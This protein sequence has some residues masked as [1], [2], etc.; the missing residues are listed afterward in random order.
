[1]KRYILIIFL[2]FTGCRKVDCN[3]L[4]ETYRKDDCKIIVSNIPD[5]E[6]GH[7]FEIEGKSLNTGKDTIYD[8]ENRWFCSFYKFINANDTIIKRKGELTFNVHKRDTIL[9]FDWECEGKVYK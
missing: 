9:T 6:S 1:M 7:N 8:E 5:R 2:V 3:L 4:S